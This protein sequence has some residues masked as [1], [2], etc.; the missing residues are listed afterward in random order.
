MK[1]GSQRLTRSA[2]DRSA[3]ARAADS[4][5]PPKSPITPMTTD[6]PLAGPDGPRRISAARSKTADRREGFEEIE[7]GRATCVGCLANLAPG[8]AATEL[9]VK[10][11]VEWGETRRVPPA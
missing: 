10:T 1:A 3:A 2:T 5:A 7:R 4:M 8:R 6:S 9:P 11:G